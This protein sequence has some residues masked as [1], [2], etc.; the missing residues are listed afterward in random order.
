MTAARF[1]QISFCNINA[2]LPNSYP[3]HCRY[4]LRQ[5]FFH[6]IQLGFRDFQHR[7]G[8]PDSRIRR[9]F[10]MADFCRIQVSDLRLAAIPLMPMQFLRILYLHHAD[11]LCVAEMCCYVFHIVVAWTLHTGRLLLTRSSEKRF[12]TTFCFDGVDGR[13]PLCG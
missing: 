4:N 8:R 5:F 13:T 2:P 6:Q 11:K 10:E 7:F 3:T 9:L 12:R 1:F